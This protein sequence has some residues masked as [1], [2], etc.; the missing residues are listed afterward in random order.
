MTTVFSVKPIA[1]DFSAMRTGLGWAQSWAGEDA[2][3]CKLERGWMRLMA[4]EKNGFVASWSWPTPTIEENRFFLIP[5]FVAH[6]LSGPAAWD[7]SELQVMAHRNLVGFILKI[8]EQDLRLQWSWKASDFNAP[9]EFTPMSQLP[10]TMMSAPYVKLADEIHLALANLI[11]LTVEESDQLHQAGA[12]LIDFTPG[13]INIDGEAITQGKQARYYFTPRMLVRG[14]EIVR[15]RQV[16]FVM[17]PIN[18]GRNSVLYLS[19]QREGWQVHCAVL[20]VGVS[21]DAPP[22]TL[23]IRETRTPMQDGPW[24]TIRP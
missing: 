23:T 1:L 21:L 2:I 12:V 6:I 24:P 14:L 16:G 9:R 17:Q 4:A 8:D 19:C 15:E 11:K 22:P 7:V 10:D 5:P 13:Q 20:S 18:N 3:L